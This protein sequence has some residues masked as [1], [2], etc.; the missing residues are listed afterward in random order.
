[1]PSRNSY[2]L[3]N[4]VIEG[5]FKNVYDADKPI[6]AADNMW[7]NLSEHIMSHV[8][9]FMFTMKN[10]SNGSLHHFQVIE[11]REKGSYTIDK[12]NVKS[13]KKDFDDFLSHVDKYSKSLEQKGGKRLRYVEVEDEDDSTTTDYYPEIVRTSPIAMF[14]Y[15]TRYYYTASDL[16]CCDDS[17]STLNPQMAVVKTPIF[18][19]VFK[20]V[21]GTFMAIW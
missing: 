18:T 3:I 21:L 4:P 13:N 9:K 16:L 19:P 6:E 1:M 14:H 20:P 8:P 10:I 15:N 5:S 12:I 7:K 17:K 2:Q 11:N